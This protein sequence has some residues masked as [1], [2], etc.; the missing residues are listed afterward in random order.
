MTEVKG[1][2]LEIGSAPNKS[3]SPTR[4]NIKITT[5]GLRRS[6]S[7]AQGA[8]RRPSSPPSAVVRHIGSGRIKLAGQ[9]DDLN[10][11]VSGSGSF[12]GADL[13]ARRVRVSVSGSG[14]VRANVAE[15]LE[16]EVSGSGRIEYL[17]DPK[18]KSE[19]SGS[20]SVRPA[21]R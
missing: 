14:R 13:I 7:P 19:V 12:D 1:G 16:A 6:M 5:I 21:G 8:L 15:E 10:V 4:L 17:G 9:V 3:I 2:T 11:S 20:G 18:V